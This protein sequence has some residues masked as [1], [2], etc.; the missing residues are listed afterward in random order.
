M[1]SGLLS[2]KSIL[3]SAEEG[4]FSSLSELTNC[5]RASML[6]PGLTGDAARLKVLIYF[7]T[8]FR[9]SFTIMLFI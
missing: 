2:R 6:L 5:M 1:A 8:A 7:T 4:H 3:M 9:F